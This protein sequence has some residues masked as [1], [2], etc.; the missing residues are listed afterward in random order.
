[1]PNKS[2]IAA[3]EKALEFEKAGIDYYSKAAERTKHPNA[4][5]MFLLLV[6]EEGKHIDYLQN[7][8]KNLSA[9][10]RWPEKITI[11][12][13]RDFHLI[14]KEEAPKIDRN[15]RISTDELEAL[16]FAANMEKK[17]RA[18]YLDLAEKASNPL[19]KELFTIL[20]DWEKGHIEFIDDFYQYFQDTGLRTEE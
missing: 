15:V 18:M 5:S 3:L 10:G 19:E 9:E 12:L 16:D 4:K 7:L 2:S 6:D 11:K 17:G 1:M 14:F 13:D 20:A 8:H